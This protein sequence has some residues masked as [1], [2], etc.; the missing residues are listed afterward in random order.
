MILP[1]AFLSAA[2]GHEEQEFRQAAIEALTEGGA[3]DYMIETL[4]SI[5]YD[6]GAT[7]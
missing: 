4:E 7:A 2:G 6:L 3:L 5:A 1:Q